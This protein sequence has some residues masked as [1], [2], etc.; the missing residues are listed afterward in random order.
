MPNRTEAALR[1]QRLRMPPGDYRYCACSRLHYRV[2]RLT[3]A[4]AAS[5][6]AP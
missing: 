1:K 6:F 4:S 5:T 2:R 3:F